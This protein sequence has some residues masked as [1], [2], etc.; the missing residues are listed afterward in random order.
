MKRLFFALEIP[1]ANKSTIATWRSNLITKFTNPVT[2]E[3]LHLTLCFLGQINET[4]EQ[5]I[6]LKMAEIRG[7]LIEL[8]FT[9]LGVFHQAK[10]AY[11]SPDIVPDA[12]DLLVRQQVQLA[13]ECGIATDHRTYFPHITIA[14]KVSFLAKNP[15]MPTFSVT[16]KKIVLYHSVSTKNGIEY[17]KIKSWSL[18]T[19]R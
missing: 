2:A 13:R 19:T 7:Q 8:V 9:H 5:Q 16:F 3:N 18:G 6:M 17:H 4:V 11:L 14:R 15:I 10:V 12:L 1:K